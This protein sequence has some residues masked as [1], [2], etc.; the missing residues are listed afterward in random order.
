[1]LRNLLRNGI[2]WI[3]VIGAALV[4]AQVI[5]TIKTAVDVEER[6][7]RIVTTLEPLKAGDLV[8][9]KARQEVVSLRVQ[10][11]LRGLL[12]NNLVIATGP[13]ITAFVALVGALLGL[14]NY[15]DTRKKESADR[16]VAVAREQHEREKARLDRAAAE[17]KEAIDRLVDAAQPLKRMAGIVGLQHFFSADMREYHVRALT[18]LAMAARSETDPRV[19]ESIRIAF[20]Q[21]VNNVD[22]VVL[23]Q[24]WQQ[25]A[26][27]QVSLRGVHF[28]G[29]A[30]RALDFRD[31][32]LEDAEFERCDL[33]GARFTAALLKGA[34]FRKCTLHDVDFSYAD[35]AGAGLPGSTLKGATLAHARVLQLDLAG[36][37]LTGARFDVD[38]LP[39]ELVR[40][41]RNA[42][43]DPGIKERLLERYGPQPQGPKVLMLMWEIPPLV[44]GGSWTACYH[45]VRNLRRRG[46]DVTVVVPW[47]QESI[48]DT[49]PFGAEVEVV[50]LGIEPPLATPS[51]YGGTPPWSPYGSV[52]GAAGPGYGAPAWSPYGRVAAAAS[53]YGVTAPYLAG[54]PYGTASSAYGAT[55]GRATSSTVLRLMDEYRRA[56]TRLLRD[57]P[58][59]VIHAHDWVTFEAA[60]A[61][62]KQFGKP[63]VAHFH[64]IETER[65]AQ[66]PD[67]IIE[68]IE[69]SAAATAT[70][71]VAPS[72]VTAARIAHRYG[73]DA[74][75]VRVVPNA[76]SVEHIAPAQLGSF[77]SMRAVFVGRLTPQKAP[78]RFGEVAR[79]VRAQL[80]NAQFWVFGSGE[81]LPQLREAGVWI[82]GPVDWP[83]RSTAYAD[84]SVVLL[85]SRAEPFGMVVLEAM[86]HRVPVVYPQD[87][88]A[89]EVLESG[90]ALPADDVER[91][92]A[93]LQRLFTDRAYWEDVAQAQADEIAAYPQRGYELRIVE[94]W[95]EIASVATKP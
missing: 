77:Q 70:A 20:E 36:A 16:A 13:M 2:F 93:Q 65:R 74:A 73:V 45:L 56:L 4:L 27:Y 80:S 48:L 34:T 15:L 57:R 41:W 49:P 91:M 7:T 33:S 88:G 59:E 82:R 84:A 68:R 71:L 66:A 25:F 9:A 67:P 63:W 46:A 52:Y 17:L 83:L 44:A 23:Q 85:P 72:A 94:L 43:F 75:R 31:A 55:Q 35:F 12:W 90:I 58:C 21:A 10:N 26:T 29:R 62:A 79:R 92:A 8:D 30:M 1:M 32:Q 95:N 38:A 51:P 37:D 39:W 78:E 64:S 69:R 60:G 61:V 89:A 42:T 50:A 11:E 54:G 18:A 5:A 40:N 47:N 24:V 3:V 81:D 76:L 19:Q 6:L 14:R 28:V 87:S 22:E 53:P 86:Q